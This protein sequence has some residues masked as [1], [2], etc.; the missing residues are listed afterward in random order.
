[1][2]FEEKNPPRRFEVG[3][4]EKITLADCG[5]LHLA[6]D[7]QITFVTESGAEYDVA[8]KSWG[9]YATPSLNGRLASFGLRACLVKSPQQRYYVFVLE[10]GREAEFEAYLAV[11][12][13]TVVAWISSTEDLESLERRLAPAPGPV[14]LC[15]GTAFSTRFRYD[16][17]PAGEIRFAFAAGQV[18]RR[19]VV[20]CR[21]CGHFLSV[22]I[23]DISKLYQGDYVDSNYGAAG[24]RASF[25]RITGLPPERSDNA[26]RVRR[27]HEFAFPRASSPGPSVLD[28][29]SGLCVFLNGMK[30]LGWSATALDP[31]ARSVE[32]A[33]AT[34]GVSAIHG[35]Y[36]RC[37]VPARFDLV[38]FNRVLEHVAEPVPMLAKAA[39]NLARGGTVYVEL[40]DGEA[41]ADGGKDREEFFIDHLHVFSPTSLAILARRAGFRVLRLE[42][43]REPSGKFT[44]YAF[45]EPE[46]RRTP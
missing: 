38:T 16:E 35:D 37:P 9:F 2:K 17:P 13:H 30:A 40:P 26:G 10:K 39:E 32:H 22:H 27:V 3:R 45:L 21:S 1:M 6:P 31:D 19:E 33:R 24:L 41:A 42:R 34:V 12:E 20:E 14:C 46:E 4:G 18:Y 15:G 11:E 8:R 25:D 5:R 44:L 29:G 7:E 43:L 36:L 23:M 28:V